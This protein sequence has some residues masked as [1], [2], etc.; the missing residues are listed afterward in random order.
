M[1]NLFLV[2]LLTIAH[3]D[4]PDW[5]NQK[6]FRINK[7]APRATSMPFSS[8]QS[9]L[10]NKRLDSPFCQLLN[11]DWKYKWSPDPAKRPVEFYKPE[12]DVSS[13]DGIKVPAN[14]ELEGYGTPLYTN[15]KYPFKKDPPR[16]M[17]EPPRN[18]TTFKNRNPVSSYRRNFTI[19]DSWQ[20]R[21]TFITFN[22][23]NS[24]FYLWVNGQKIGYSQDSRTPAEF[25]LTKYLKQG[26]NTLAVEV[27]RYS[28]GSYLEDQDFWRLSGIFRDVYL[29]SSP[30]LQLRDFFARGGLD[31]S[32][33]NGTFSLKTKVRSLNGKPRDYSIQATIFNPDGSVLIK[34]TIKGRTPTDGEDIATISQSGLKISAWSAESPTLY[35]MVLTLKS[36]NNEDV[37]HFATKIGFS[38][39]EIKNGQ[40]L[41]NGQPIMI[42]GVNRHDHD[43]D[44]GHYI[45]EERMLEDIFIA[46]RNNIN[47]IRTCHYPNDPRFYELCDQYGL[48]LCAEANIESHG[49]GYGKESL[50]KDGSWKE[51]HV[52]R[53]RNNVE[54]FKNHPSIILWSMGNEAGDGQNF[55]ASSNWIRQNDPSRPIHYEQGK[56]AAHVDLFTPMYATHKACEKYCREE[57]KKPLAK[58][59]PLIQCEYSHAMGNSSGG[60]EDYWKLFEKE[61]LLQGGF[62]WDYID[63]GLR[64]TKK[65]AQG[66]TVEYF[67]YGGDFGDKPND[68]NFCCN[69][70]I[71]SDRKPTPQLQEV[72]KLYQNIAADLVKAGTV[73]VTNKRFFTPLD[74]VVM[75]WAITANGESEAKGIAGLPPIPAQDSADVAIK[76]PA[77]KTDPGIEYVLSVSFETTSDTPWSTNGHQVAW[78]Q[79]VMQ[80]AKVVIPDS[81]NTVEFTRGN[82]LAT[83]SG[84]SFKAVFNDKT[85]CLD[86]YTVDGR[87]L[88]VAPLHLNFWRPSTD[89]DRGYKLDQTCKVWRDA[90]SKSK[91]T[92]AK[93]GSSGDKLVI[94]TYQ[95]K[96]PAGQ[97]NATIVY[98]IDGDGRIAT[99][100]TLKPAGKNLAIIPR[101]GMQC[102][103]IQDLTTWSWYGHGPDETY[104]DRNAGGFLG[105]WSTPVSDA[106][107]PY[108]EP[109]ETGNRTGIRKA[110]LFDATGKGLQIQAFGAPLEMSAYPFAMSDLERLKHPTD[111]PVRDFITLNIDHTQMGVG[112]INSWGA[113]PLAKHQIKSNQ[114]YNYVFI[115]EPLR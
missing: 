19:P 75:R 54:A 83:V 34:P 78:E 111:I 79:F 102:Q 112:G 66:D 2:A 9:A 29:W 94:L 40:M 25:D 7:E 67:A 74:D 52:D 86:Q 18:Y 60:L 84:N 13:W 39:S 37:A 45:T 68:G 28:D 69:G 56:K 82:G 26:E 12:F 88:L 71:T 76:I 32:Y 4:Q 96:V 93:V 95:L 61:R 89:N 103:L 53:N 48:Y 31:G 107:F 70:I 104:I 42:K 27:Y 22:G 108:V 109:Q 90:G 41:V 77:L 44:T 65:N 14:V 33:R 87:E 92:S 24:A 64:Q 21:H 36:H 10:E 62:I 51:A 115:I 3:A 63:Q 81:G 73:R 8:A 35:P 97:T 80:P 30:S 58:Q 6:I 15:I 17:G 110:S 99:D 20:G 98:R 72:R 50:A 55:V 91:V 105:K 23:V 49:M 5:E 59:R 106:W 57:E 47:A 114:D 46:K 43:P 101:V 11:G 38:R 113:W 16:V 85:G 1:K 100:V